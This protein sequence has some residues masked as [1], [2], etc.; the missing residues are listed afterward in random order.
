MMQGRQAPSLYLGL[1]DFGPEFGLLG[2]QKLVQP[3][4][5]GQQR[6]LVGELHAWKQLQRTR[7]R[8]HL[9]L[10]QIAQIFLGFGAMV[11]SAFRLRGIAAFSGA[12][13]VKRFIINL[14]QGERQPF[15]PERVNIE[16]PSLRWNYGG[17]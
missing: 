2:P 6:R 14:P 8:R 3:I 11:C 17:D 9:L 4:E 7:Q 13:T 16:R 12:D 1:D 10:A 15:R 5:F